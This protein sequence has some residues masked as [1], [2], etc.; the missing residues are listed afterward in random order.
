MGGAAGPVGAIS[1]IAGAGL[2]AY[3]MILSSQGVAAGDTFK[4]PS[5]DA[6]AQRGRVA[7]VQTGCSGARLA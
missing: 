3:G 6:A 5:L 2:G 1:S 4:T 7:A